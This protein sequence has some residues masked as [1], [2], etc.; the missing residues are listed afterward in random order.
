MLT[1]SLEWSTNFEHVSN[2]FKANIFLVSV[3]RSLSPV[4]KDVDQRFFTHFIYIVIVICLCK[5]KNL[6]FSLGA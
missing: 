2:L 6:C 1:I 5:L 3:L 4:E